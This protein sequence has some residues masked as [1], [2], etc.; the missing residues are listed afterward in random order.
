M[1]R[2][3][4]FSFGVPGEK[5]LLTPCVRTDKMH[6]CVRLQHAVAVLEG[7]RNRQPEFFESLGG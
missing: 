4:V 5:T 1:F 2:R 7:F 6:T 3:A